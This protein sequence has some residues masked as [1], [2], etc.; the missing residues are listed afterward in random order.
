MNTEVPGHMC[1]GKTEKEYSEI[2][3]VIVSNLEFILLFFSVFFH[4]NRDEWKK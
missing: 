3:L 4:E 1:A 2:L